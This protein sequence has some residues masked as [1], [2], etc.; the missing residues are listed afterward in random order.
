MGASSAKE[1]A[2]PVK[3]APAGTFGLARPRLTTVIVCVV[4]AMYLLVPVKDYFFDGIYFAQT[5]EDSRSPNLFLFHPNHLFYTATGYGVYRV[6]NA[7]GLHTRALTWMVLLNS[8]LSALAAGTLLQVLLLITRS[9]YLSS[10]LTFAFAFSATWWRYSPNADAY[11]PSIFLLLVSFLL[12]LPGRKSKPFALAVT[13]SFAML[14]HQLAVM[15][16]PVAI[17]GLLLQSRDV[18]FKI[19]LR[20]AVT[21]SAVAVA[22][23]VSVY[24]LVFRWGVGRPFPFTEFRHWVM[25]HDPAVGFEFTFLHSLSATLHGSAQLLFATKASQLGSDLLSRV[26]LTLSLLLAV[27]GILQVA[28]HPD[29]LQQ[30][31]RAMRHF[32]RRV[33]FLLGLWIVMYVGFLFFWVPENQHYRPFYA[34]PIF[35][36]AGAL[37]SSYERLKD[38]SRRYR[39]A[40]LVGSYALLNLSLLI[41]PISREQNIPTL[42]FSSQIRPAWPPGTVIYYKDYITT[43]SNWT[44]RYFNPQTRWRQVAPATIPVSDPELESVYRAGGTVWFDTTLADLPQ[45]NEPAFSSWLSQHTRPGSLHRL[46]KTGWNVYFLQIFPAARAD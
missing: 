22:I 40:L 14:F 9:T 28:R 44:M 37:W 41:L 2:T 31:I 42:A 43:L 4:L 23:V 10:I 13:H 26:L 24:V 34:A 7:L 38:T 29:E 17:A 5:V 32:D 1:V 19:R 12:V 11:I 39:A 33:A 45:W 35:L 46:P 8:L 18:P 16:Y 27:A 21:Y 30:A 6:A 3:T 15:F 25:F 20:R 36:L